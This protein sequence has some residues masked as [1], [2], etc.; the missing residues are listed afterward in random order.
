MASSAG[1]GAE[2]IVLSPADF[3]LLDADASYEGLHVLLGGAARLDAAT[4]LRSV[5]DRAVAMLLAAQDDD[6][7]DEATKSKHPLRQPLKLP[8]RL[9]WR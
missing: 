9:G 1:A 6:E 5:T 8:P 2:R 7:D 4:P 3:E